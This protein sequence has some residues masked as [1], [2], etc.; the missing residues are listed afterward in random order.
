MDYSF[1]TWVKR[2]RKALD[3]TQ[4]ELAQRV[5]CSL[6]LIFKIESDERRP[7]R[8]VSEL[9]MAHLEIP[10]D[11]RDLFL[12]VARRGKSANHLESLDPPAQSQSHSQ[13]IPEDVATPPRPHLPLP[14]TPL[15]G[16]GPE[17]RGILQQIQDPS[18][19]LLTLTGPGGVGKTRLALEVAHRLRDTSRYQVC[20]VS[21]AGTSGAG[22]IVPAIADALGFV[23]SGTG[24]LKFQ[25]FN[26]LKERPI[27]LVLDN[28]EHLLDGIELLNE[29]LEYALDVKLLTTSREPLNLRTEWIFDV[30]GLPIPAGI[31]PEDLESNS[32]AALFVQRA[33][34]VNVNFTPLP[35]DLAAIQQICQLV[36]GLPLGLELAAAWVRLLSCAEIA[37]EIEQNLDFLATTTIDIPARQ[38]SLRATFEYSW[39]LL[40]DEEQQVLARL[41]VF[42]GG[43][44]QAAAEAVAE[45]TLR[46]LAALI[47]KSLLRRTDSGQY[48]LHELVRQ[49]GAVHLH[50]DAHNEPLVRD[51][52]SAHYL[53][54]WRASEP[55]LKGKE[56]REGLRELIVDIDNFR[57]AWERA[58]S[59]RQ[60][61]ILG[62]CLRSFLIVYDLYGWHA[63]GIERLEAVIEALRSLPG[64]PIQ[65]TDVLGLALAFEGWFYFRLG[66]LEEARQCFDEGVE[67][68][69]SLNDPFGLAD[70]LTLFSPVMTSLGSADDARQYANEGLAAARASGDSW[71]IAH[72]LMMKAGI[73]AGWGQYDQAYTSS[74]EALTRFRDLGDIRL[75]A[76]TLNTLGFAA[77]QLS[78]FDE[79]RESLQESLR[80]VTAAEDPWSAGTAYGNLGIVELAGGNSA[81]AQDLLQKCIPLFADL[82]MLG[83]VAYYMI[84]LGEAVLMEGAPDDAESHWLDAIRIARE[85]QALPTELAI[86]IRLARLEAQA[87]NN[88]RAYAWATLVAEHPSAWQESKRL[89]ESL[90]SELEPSLS[91]QQRQSGQITNLQDSLEQI[92]EEILS[93]SKSAYGNA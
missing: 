34:H 15:I 50:E 29:L 59:Q 2:R 84:Y 60:F 61:R 16:R 73:L 5:G 11:Q 57:V 12:R 10:L 64:I 79:A 45:A 72:A 7:S 1:G 51:R 44:S 76:V 3:L 66:Q 37:A 4:Q 36:E 42:R 54:L 31:E 23:F 24:E 75:T 83:D 55:R 74:R 80:L 90:R 71:R 21:L 86:L 65:D 56:Q 35:E 13:G 47:D 20:F 89:A 67:L 70:V 48:D 6:S 62:Q 22:F 92:V 49:Y 28:L 68:L 32:A 26:L 43:F 91:L 41:S 82:G 38:R 93:R 17:L 39:H 85:T 27:L 46:N 69:K 30:Q 63:R 52:H 78:Q 40:S 25:L 58:I 33:K 18:C 77:I 53:G 9:L 88:V 14:L 8:Q 87:G 81:D 19:R